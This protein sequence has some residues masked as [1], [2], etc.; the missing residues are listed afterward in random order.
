MGK[1]H[2][3]MFPVVDGYPSDEIKQVK[4]AESD[5][6]LELVGLADAT[7]R[8][9][10]RARRVPQN[11]RRKPERLLG[12]QRGRVADEHQQRAVDNRP[13]NVFGKSHQRGPSA[14][15]A[16]CHYPQIPSPR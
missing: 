14:P 16:H 1:K 9:A 5:N 8:M 4:P 6:P 15:Q 11:P 12:W 3:K 7:E 2:S 13:R 10:A